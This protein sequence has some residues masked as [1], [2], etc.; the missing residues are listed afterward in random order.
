MTAAVESDS[1][2]ELFKTTLSKNKSLIPLSGSSGNELI[3]ISFHGQLPGFFLE[4][5]CAAAAIFRLFVFSERQKPLTKLLAALDA[6]GII[7]AQ[8]SADAGS[9]HWECLAS[10]RG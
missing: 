2:W 6:T 1:F 5:F 3:G 4:F 8:C 9:L 10:L 7:F